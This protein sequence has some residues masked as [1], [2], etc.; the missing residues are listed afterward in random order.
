MNREKCELIEHMLTN[1]MR[2]L[3][4][5]LSLSYVCITLYGSGCLLGPSVPG[6]SARV[7]PAV[8]LF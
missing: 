2:V 4:A 3:D 7:P 8:L 5:S 6:R 1:I